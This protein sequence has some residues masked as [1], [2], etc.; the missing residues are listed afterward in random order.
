MNEAA[1]DIRK[2]TRN[3]TVFTNIRDD[4]EKPTREDERRE[5]WSW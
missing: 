1:K 4:F 5:N 3:F 2:A